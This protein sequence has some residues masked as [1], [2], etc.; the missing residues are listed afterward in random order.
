MFGPFGLASAETREDVSLGSPARVGAV[1]FLLSVAVLC[2]VSLL[3]VSAASAQVGSVT[4]HALPGADSQPA[5][6]AAGSDDALWFTEQGVN[7]IGRI[8]TGGTITE[9]SIPTANSY[10]SGITNG[11]D[12]A[13]W[14]TEGGA[15][16]GAPNI[17][18]ITTAGAITE[19]PSSPLNRPIS[20]TRGPDGALWFTSP[21]NGIGRMTT[22]GNVTQYPTP[23]KN[24]GPSGIVTGSDGALWF[25][26]SG[27]DKVG[28]ITTAGAITEYP[29]IGFNVGVGPIAAGPDGALWYS[30]AGGIM[31][32]T[33]DGAV[34]A[35][36]RQ[37]GND[38]TTGP[39]G[40]LWFTSGS[41]FV[42]RLTMSGALSQQNLADPHSESSKYPGGITAGPDGAMWFTEQGANAIARLVPGAA[43][44]GTASARSALGTALNPTGRTASIGAILKAGGYIASVKAPAPG[45]AKV[46]WYFVPNGAHLAAKPV[47]VASGA[48]TLKKAGKA[49]LKVTLSSK[50]KALLKKSKALKLT[51]RGTFKPRGAK[52]ESAS[53]TFKLKR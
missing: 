19:Y 51:A 47:V 53:H 34:T 24:S 7:K 30:Q 23:T 13:L 17:G 22:D 2:V 12:G 3:F 14:F 45:A 9:Y 39:D 5:H 33:T 10:P 4:E 40:A 11:P 29:T 15:A 49:R 46:V 1:V 38:I 32:M 26:E 27:V 6:I 36:V 44:P 50:G 35:R 18:R 20:I 28:R 37:G 8:T 21:P 43:V 48:K 31:R 52:S 16:N 25:T 42:D 41:N